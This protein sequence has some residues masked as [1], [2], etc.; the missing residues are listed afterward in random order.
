MSDYQLALTPKTEHTCENKACEKKFLSR[1]RTV[2]WC[3][4]CARE[5]KH[6]QQEK[7]TIKRRAAVRKVRPGVRR[8][9][10]RDPKYCKF[11]RDWGY[12]PVCFPEAWKLYGAFLTWLP[13]G[14]VQYTI[15]ACDPAHTTHNGG[16]S[17]GPDSGCAPL[18]GIHHDEYDGRR[19]L[20]NG[21]CGNKDHHRAFEEYYGID[22]KAVAAAW[23]ALYLKEQPK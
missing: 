22:M 23:Y 9:P 13:P 1:C 10:M 21:E 20:P 11:L 19:K 2:R 15:G 17:K 5:R 18:D 8:G 12:C 4:K 3:F 7:W 16:A 14:P 6:K